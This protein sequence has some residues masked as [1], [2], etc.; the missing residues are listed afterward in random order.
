MEISRLTSLV[1]ELQAQIANENSYKDQ[2]VFDPDMESIAELRAAFQAER[3]GSEKLEK[4]LAAALSDNA[5][6][7]A[8]IHAKDNNLSQVH[9]SS[10]PGT[11]N[12]TN[13][14]PIDSFLAE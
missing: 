11:S 6:S 3:A 9:T 2:K 7:A 14:N 12:T 13:I 10:P 1:S 4:A 8:E 5:T